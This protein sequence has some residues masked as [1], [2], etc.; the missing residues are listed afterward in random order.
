MKTT[1]AVPE[2]FGKGGYGLGLARIDSPCGTV[3]GHG[4]DTLGHH[5]SAVTTADGRRS[6]VT[7]V[8][9]NLGDTEPN[10]GVA[11]FIRVVSAADTVAI[12]RMLGKPAPA[13]VLA[14]LHS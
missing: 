10:D 9:A 3:W 7:D 6:A 2:D 5:S 1:V 13:D 11:R 8:T 4:G 14:A 12:C